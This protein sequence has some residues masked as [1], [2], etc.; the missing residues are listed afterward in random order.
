MIEKAFDELIV[1][2]LKRSVGGL[3]YSDGRPISRFDQLL[4][5]GAL[6]SRAVRAFGGVSLYTIVN[7]LLTEA[8]INDLKRAELLAWNMH[9]PGG[10]VDTFFSTVMGDISSGRLVVREPLNFLR[11]NDLPELQLLSNLSWSDELCAMAIM[12]RY[13]VKKSDARSWLSWHG[14]AIPEWLETDDSLSASQDSSQPS[15]GSSQGRQEE[16]STERWSDS[17]GP[18]KVKLRLRFD[19]IQIEIEGRGYCPTC[20]PHG[21]VASIRQSCEAA[22][23]KLFNARTSFDNAWRELLALG[24]V[25]SYNHVAYGGKVDNK[26]KDA[27]LIGIDA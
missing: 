1:E 25:R 20:I 26:E 16:R 10:V 13:A 2:R 15:D 17:L 22:D 23:P 11:C 21:G 27:G 8:S 14:H 9:L 5:Q 12:V 7:G 24:K 6:T 18:G 3:P 4:A 19:A